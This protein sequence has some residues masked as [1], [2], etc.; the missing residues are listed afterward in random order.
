MRMLK[1]DLSLFSQTI[2]VDTPNLDTSVACGAALACYWKHER[3]IELI[4]PVTAEDIG[5]L[6]LGNRPVCLVESGTPLPFPTEGVHADQSDFYV[7]QHGQKELIIPFYAGATDSSHRLSGTVKVP[8]PEGTRQGDLVKIKLTVD[9]NKILH[10]WYS[11][12]HGEFTAADPFNDPWTPR[13]VEPAEKHLLAFRRQMMGELA[14]KKEVPDWM[15]LQE[16]SLLRKAGQLEEA[17]VALRDFA[18]ERELTG[19]CANLLSLVCGEQGN[20]SEELHYAEKA[21]S[22]SPKAPI[23]VGNFGFVLANVGRT[24]QAIS[25]M[26]LALEM[27]PDLDYLYE[28]LGQI[29]RQQGKE[30]DA[31]REFRQAIRVLEKNIHGQQSSPNQWTNLARL[32]GKIGDYHQAAEAQS[33]S[34]DAHLNEVFEGDHRHRVAGPDS[35]F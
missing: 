5:I 21:A 17:E 4:K 33:R 16:A 22:L 11:I 25:T 19:D 34:M 3:G 14:A 23:L 30:E 12:G 24:D 13:P 20:K 2:V 29:Y 31:L 7:P 6:T 28:R 9:H 27:N 32:Y 18:A 15:L 10:W 26:R 8:L 35:G 1:A